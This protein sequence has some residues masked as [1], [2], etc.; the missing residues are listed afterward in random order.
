MGPTVKLLVLLLTAVASPALAASACAPA[1]AEAD[2]KDAPEPWRAAVEALVRSTTQAGHPW[3]C[4]GGTVGL[5]VRGD[6]V[7]LIVVREGEEPIERDLP[8]PEDVVPL[9]QALL[10]LPRERAVPLASAPTPAAS[11]TVVAPAPAPS[12][13]LIVAGQLG[14]RLAG[15]SRA[16][17][18]GGEVSA[19]VPFDA[20][21]PAVH[22]RYDGAAFQRGSGLNTVAVG[23]RFSRVFRA[24]SFDLR[25]GLSAAAVVLQ[26]D[27][28]RPAGQDTRIDGRVGALV[29]V[30]IPVTTR[31]HAVVTLDADLALGRAR[32]VVTA[33]AN[34]DTLTPFPFFTCGASVGVEVRL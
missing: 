29:A 3:S 21:L 30:A 17:L 2:V 7:T 14:G 8:L 19:A 12:T 22:V 15:G 28:P 24:S 31:L 11:P 4:G 9:G 5:R 18:L 33:A 25:A 13:R 16:A 34:G 26:R 10:S 1:T 20:W 6:A 23:A 32:E 27:L